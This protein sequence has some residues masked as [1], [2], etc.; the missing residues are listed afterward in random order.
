MMEVRARVWEE[1]EET[2]IQCLELPKIKSTKPTKAEAV[3]DI[4]AQLQD[5]K[6]KNSPDSDIKLTFMESS[7]III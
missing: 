7:E 4:T 5:W 3:S 1:I 2:I 6:T